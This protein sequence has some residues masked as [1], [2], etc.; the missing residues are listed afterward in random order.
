MEFM[1]FDQIVRIKAT[2]ER[3]KTLPKLQ[4]FCTVAQYAELGFDLWSPAD[5]VM[6]AQEKYTEHSWYQQNF[7]TEFGYVLPTREVMDTLAELLHD[8]G[9]VLEAGSGSG[10]LS[11]ELTR[12]GMETFA[13]DNGDPSLPIHKRDAQSDA[14][15][16]VSDHFGAVLMTWPPFN[17]PFALNVAMAM[18]P[19]QILVYEGE[20]GGGCTADSAF[21][22]YLVDKG[23][24]ETLF[25]LSD[26]LDAAH[27]TFSMNRDHWLMFRKRPYG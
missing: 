2:L 4:P 3:V 23:C 15:S 12:L 25:H 17:G 27:V 20:N 13:V 26:R 9:P 21:F 8:V 14:A 1:E 6:P 18:T 22:N 11:Q 7:L 10:Y 5:F 19:G 24:W 16:C